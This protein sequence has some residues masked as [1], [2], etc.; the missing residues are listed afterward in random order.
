MTKKYLQLSCEQRY[1]IEVLLKADK[2]Q[3][4]IAHLLGVHKS[5]ISRE[6]HR[7]TAK[8][9]AGA[10]QYHAGGA[11]RKTMHRHKVKA[12]HIRFT[13]RMKQQARDWLHIDKLS[14]EL[15]SVR[16]KQQTGDFVSHETIYGWI[17]ECKKSNRRKDRQD[18]LLYKTLRHGKHRRKR[19]AFTDHRGI[20][21][22]RI[23]IDQRPKIVAKR[24]R[25]GDLEIDLMV[26]KNYK[27]G[28][29]VITDRAT[30]KTTL[31]K[32]ESK[33]SASIV[34]K[35]KRCLIRQKDWIKTIT[36]DN[37]LAFTLHEQ[38]AKSLEA[39]TY[40]TRP[41][42]AQDKGTIENRIGVIRRFYPKKTDMTLVTKKEIK[43]VERL[44]NNRP[45]RKFNYR[46]PNEVFAQF[47]GGE[48]A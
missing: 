8:R 45:V 35:I 29:L 30:L 11:Q 1:Q 41:Y 42:T 36:F 3:Q 7:N 39:K 34:A 21:P 4:E 28:L 20:I 6:L 13:D 16:G 37:D 15:I 12:K 14:P 9:G 24:K 40:F 19:G 5:T 44:I 18:K 33:Q 26:G 31:E 22:N 17:W 23:S 10:K 43:I 48:I 25:I 38:V 27:G 46:T 32:F 2:S 47:I